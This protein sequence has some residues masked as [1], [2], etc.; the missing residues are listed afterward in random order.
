MDPMWSL[1]L[2]LRPRMGYGYTVI[3]VVCWVE[4]PKQKDSARF[5]LNHGSRKGVKM[6]PCEWD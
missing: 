6:S 5:L 4:L 1:L 2:L 3:Q